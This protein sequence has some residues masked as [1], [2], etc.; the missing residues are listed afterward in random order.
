MNINRISYSLI[1][2]VIILMSSCRRQPLLNGLE[3]INIVNTDRPI[4]LDIYDIVDS[5]SYIPLETSAVRKT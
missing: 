4:E 3:A 2:A 1:V 5:I